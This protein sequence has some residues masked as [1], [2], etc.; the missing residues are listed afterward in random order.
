[1]ELAS[2]NLEGIFS[3]DPVFFPV[4]GAKA[5]QRAEERRKVEAYDNFS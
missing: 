4:Y 3:H 1:M 5:T 2:P